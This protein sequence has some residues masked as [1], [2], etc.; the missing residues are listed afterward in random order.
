MPSCI[1]CVVNALVGFGASLAESDCL[2]R[3]LAANERESSA[4]DAMLLQ[5]GFEFWPESVYRRVRR[6]CLWMDCWGEQQAGNQR[7]ERRKNRM[8]TRHGAIIICVA[9]P[10]PE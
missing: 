4:D 9:L 8:F 5:H 3:S 2:S 7:R 10:A 1:G 6:G